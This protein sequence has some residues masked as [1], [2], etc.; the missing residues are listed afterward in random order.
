MNSYIF[1][2]KVSYL[3]G[4]LV[5]ISE[6]CHGKNYVPLYKAV[7]CLVLTDN[8]FSNIQNQISLT[9]A[10][11]NECNQCNN[12]EMIDNWEEKFKE[13]LNKWIFNIVFS[14]GI[15]DDNMY[16]QFKK[17]AEIKISYFIK[18]NLVDDELKVWKFQIGQGLCYTYGFDNEAYAFK[19]KN[20]L[21]VV[22]FGWSD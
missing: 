1:Q 18:D 2:E 14:R 11:I 4:Y 10:P 12:F 16:S 5:G 6:L 22:T 13:S 19:S 15:T 17:N 20:N 8:V 7:S 3:N 9:P 21:F